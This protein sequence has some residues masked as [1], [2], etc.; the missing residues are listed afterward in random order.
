MTLT[1]ILIASTGALFYSLLLPGRLRS[2]GLMLI[3]I[4]ALYWLQPALRIRYLDFALPTATLALSVLVWLMVRATEYQYQ[5]EDSLALGLTLLTVFA[6]TSTRYLVP[7]LRPTPSRPPDI[8]WVLLS[9]AVITFILG[10]LTIIKRR[11]GRLPL[12]MILLVVGIF[13]TLKAETLSIALSEWLR[14]FSGQ[15]VDLADATDIQWLGFSYV[16]FR[17]LH[18]L[19][20]RQTQKL[21]T[22]SLREHLTYIIFFPA[23]TAGPIDR[24]ERFL[25]D[26]RDLSTQRLWHAPRLGDGLTRIA[27]GVFKKFVL[28][29]TLALIALNATNASQITS[30]TGL[31]LHVYLY[32]WR[33]FL[34]FS[35]YTDIA[36]GIG[37]LLG[38][39]L[40]ENF[41]RPY[42]RSNI[43][44]FWQNWHMTLSNWVR[45][46]IFFPLSRSLL[47]LKPRP[48]PSLI[49]FAAHLTT[50]T[51]I[52][53]WHGITVNFFI[54][55]VWHGVGLFIHKLWSDRTRQ[56]Y[57]ALQ[58]H[59]HRRQA[60][61]V[62][63]NILTFQYVA[64]GWV[65]FSLPDS[66]TASEVFLK[67]WGVWA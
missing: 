46:Y 21:P 23:L 45:F 38:V 55:G 47:R 39:R 28:A 64:L 56:Q 31:W 63:G 5:R 41:N 42:F 14:G 33:L 67:L 65:W 9:L 24:A 52:G 25:G 17:L 35:G 11:W 2:W 4:V 13:V 32:A 40:P 36:I 22:L 10:L 50:M 34:D 27:V 26:L 1:Q 18:M 49:L 51:I 15:S 20:D 12:L 44:A 53:L 8:V 16:A 3:S 60:W 58:Q 66:T 37:V 54:W 7:S 57:R 19:R 59:P 48:N 6:I 29:D 43:T 62:V 30:T 61:A